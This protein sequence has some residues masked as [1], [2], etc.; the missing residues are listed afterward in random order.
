MVI[1]FGL[2]C[3]FGAQVLVSSIVM[4]VIALTGSVVCVVFAPAVIEAAGEKDPR[5]IVVDEVA[6]QAV[7]FIGVSAIGNKE[8]LIVTILGFLAFRVFDII[9]PWP[10]RKLEKFDK[11]WGILADDLM[12]GV[13]AAVVLQILIACNFIG[14]I[15]SFLVLDGSMNTFSAVALGSLQGLTE[16]L[17]VSS[18]GHLV[19]LE[20]IMDLNP[21]SP[22]MLMFD[23][24]THV[25]TV[26][27]ILVVF[28]KSIAVFLK[29]L[30]A[31]A[32][33][34]RSPVT[35]YHRSPSVHFLVLGG[36]ATLVTGVIGILFKDSFEA[37]RGRLGIVSI[38]WIITATLLLITDYRKK[39]RLSLRSF[40]VMGA[41][42]I[43]LAQAMAIMP[44]ISRSGT[45]ICA[46]I[47][48]GLHRRWAIE[49]SF[50][51]A[52]PAILGASAI[53]LI[54]D[55][56]KLGT[57]SPMVFT[58]GIITACLV[59][60]FALKLLIKVSMTGKFR[61]FAVYCYILAGF[62]AF[63]LL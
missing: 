49:F 15:G 19:L 61:F 21:E 39:T 17:P 3:Y 60:I 31:F 20:H 8:I 46:A 37:V 41:I 32:K 14:W 9:K 56:D 10:C 58:A 16:F 7:T 44:G 48:L 40:G 23:L 13:Y 6:G 5:R 18:S 22:E 12:A 43:G 11:G 57:L 50:L 24:A 27:A 28:R 42:I 55:F 47:L 52:I 36:L 25:G 26:I 2:L 63:Y 62:V 51:L 33:Y 1:V 45:T 38:M 59:G 30:T 34:G 54:K 35:I 29:N 53:T 4:I